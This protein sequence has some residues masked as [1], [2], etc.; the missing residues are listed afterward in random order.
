MKIVAIVN[1]VAGKG[2]E[3]QEW[4]RLLQAAGPKAVQVV[5]WWTKGRGQAE[6]LA[7]PARREGFDRII[8]VGGDGT[9][10][11]VA[12]G[13]WWEPQGR[14][15][16]LGMVP[17]GTGCD[18]LRN[19]EVGGT[20]KENLAA[21]LGETEVPVNLGL[22]RLPGLDGAPSQ[23]IFVNVLGLGFDAEVVNRFQRQR[24]FLRGKIAYISS[25]LEGLVRLKLYRLQ[26]EANGEA[27][28]AMVHTFV[29]GLGRYF[30]GG[31]LIAP[32][33]SPQSDCFQLVWVQQLSRLQALRLL[34]AFWVGRQFA[35]PQVHAS[36][37]GYLKL[38]AAPAAFVQAEGEL[39]GR[40]PIEVA[41]NKRAFN[42]AAI[43]AKNL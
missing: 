38:K 18:Y 10:F 30:G 2:Q 22:A 32:Q 35:H 25:A 33:A 13:L 21:A 7:A 37:A 24:R 31:I 26:G 1:P 36:H 39:I 11:E 16:S 6:S 12:N 15:P 5:T 19:F 23:R 28:D 9:L 42:F 3:V 27:I 8:A 20:L 29:V 34:P 40:T 43:S 14:L 4:P 17:F 41:L